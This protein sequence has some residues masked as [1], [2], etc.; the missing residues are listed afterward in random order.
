M[1]ISVDGATGGSQAG[2]M[3][4]LR[5]VHGHIAADGERLVG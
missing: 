4:D 1:R 2:A 5:G 3:D